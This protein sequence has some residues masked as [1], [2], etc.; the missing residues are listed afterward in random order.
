MPFSKTQRRLSSRDRLSSIHKR[1]IFILKIVLSVVLFLFFTSYVINTIKSGSLSM[2][3]TL[4][5]GSCSLYRPNV[6]SARLNRGDVV[7]IEAPYYEKEVKLVDGLNKVVAFLTFQKVQVSF[8]PREGW[9]NR[10]MIKRIVALPGDTI[11][12][13]DWTLYVKT[14]ESR[15][16]LSEFESSEKEYDI[17]IDP[18]NPEWDEGDPLSGNIQEFIL[19][20]GEYFLLGDNR[21]LSNDSY[22][23]G[24]L[25]ENRIKG[26]LFFTYWPLSQFGV[27]H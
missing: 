5:K 9:I 11:K 2:E 1:N 13:E 23:W 18:E 26:K 4:E 25:P 6:S 3:P 10:Y 14:A 8:Y 27:V 20:E 19:N 12:M 21:R 24:A 22:Y 17:H 7:L 16:Y 15:Y